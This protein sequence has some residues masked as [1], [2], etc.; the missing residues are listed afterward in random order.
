MVQVAVEE[1][2]VMEGPVNTEFLSIGHEQV[3]EDV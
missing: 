1:V 2:G 3:G